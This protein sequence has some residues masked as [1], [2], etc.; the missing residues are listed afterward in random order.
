V[1]V[2]LDISNFLRSHLKIRHLHVVIMLDEMLSVSRA[3]ERL[4][5]TQA[6]VS[7]TLAEVEAGF[8]F[9]LFE[10]HARGLR[11]TE[12]GREVM[13][14]LRKIIDEI[15][16]LEGL[17][18]Q[19]NTLSRGEVR[20][21]MQAY[22][23]IDQIAALVVGFKADYPN[24]NIRLRDGI[25][26]DLLEDLQYGRVDLVYGRISDRLPGNGLIAKI[27]SPVEIAIVAG[28]D[29]E[30]PQEDLETLMRRP[31][32]LP[33][34]G[35]PMRDEFDRLLIQAGH[36]QPS[37]C[38]ENNNPQLIAEVVR[39]SDRLALCP[40]PMAEIWVRSLGLQRFA[41]PGGMSSEPLGIIYADRN[42]PSPAVAAFLERQ[43]KSE[44]PALRNQ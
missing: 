28:P 8:G 3:A 26:P 12:Q 31:W 35:T 5:V 10:R 9:A 2:S 15:S 16:A 7:R 6:A 27:L 30:P 25:L 23:L 33:V 11:R 21:G 4:N 29:T 34:S 39:M 22:S 19:F 41:V 13:R 40:A 42:A 1:E 36:D 14:A 20:I 43:L 38:I 24:V 37:D 44:L 17:A 32:V 18:G